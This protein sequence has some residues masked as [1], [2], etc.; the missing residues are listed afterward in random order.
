MKSI[1]SILS[2]VAILAGLATSTNAQSVDGI[3][4]L[5]KAQDLAVNRLVESLGDTNRSTREIT[6]EV[7]D[8]TSAIST[9]QAVES[10]AYTLANERDLAPQTMT[11]GA[12][13]RT[14][15]EA[16]E[17]GVSR[18]LRKNMERE[19]SHARTL[20][21]ADGVI[22]KIQ[23]ASAD[24]GMEVADRGSFRRFLPEWAGG[25]SSYA[26]YRVPQPVG[27]DDTMVAKVKQLERQVVTM[28]AL[29]AP[30]VTK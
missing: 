22:A 27:G 9:M 25:T 4:A 30:T 13:T 3:L 6:H 26:N 19:W 1:K 8:L 5:R 15:E 2:V 23:K 24:R 7:K 18:S 21:A 20:E 29:I 10:R 28:Q 16:K 11:S 17:L 14:L 12:L